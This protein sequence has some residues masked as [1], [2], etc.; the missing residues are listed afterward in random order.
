MA[1]I[2]VV[3]PTPAFAFANWNCKLPAV[4]AVV[5]TPRTRRTPASWDESATTV[6]PLAKTTGRA[7]RVVALSGWKV[8]VQRIVAPAGTVNVTLQ[9][10]VLAPEMLSELDTLARGGAS[11]L[12]AV[13]VRAS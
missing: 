10:V 11:P 3:Q 9:S 5:T 6:V 12:G 1:L 4:A 13:L 2:V 7:A 8:L